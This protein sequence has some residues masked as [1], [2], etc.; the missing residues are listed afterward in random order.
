VCTP[1]CAVRV[2][3]K[4]PVHSETSFKQ[5]DELEAEF[6]A[7]INSNGA[8][9]ARR[10]VSLCLARAEAAAEEERRRQLLS[11]AGASPQRSA[12]VK[13]LQECPARPAGGQSPSRPNNGVL[14]CPAYPIAWNRGFY[15]AQLEPTA[16]SSTH[17][18]RAASSTGGCLREDAEDSDE[19]YERIL[20]S[21]FSI[22]GKVH[23]VLTAAREEKMQRQPRQSARLTCDLRKI[24]QISGDIGQGRAA[25]ER[26]KGANAGA[27]PS[28]RSTKPEQPQLPRTSGSRRN[29]EGSQEPGVPCIQLSLKLRNIDMDALN[30]Q[31]ST[32]GDLEA[33]VKQAVAEEMSRDIQPS[34]VD[35]RLVR[36]EGSAAMRVAVTPPAC[37]LPEVVQAVLGTSLSFQANVLEKVRN[38]PGIAAVCIGDVGVGEVSVSELGTVQ[39]QEILSRGGNLAVLAQAATGVNS[40]NEV[41]PAVAPPPPT[42]TMQQNSPQPARRDASSL[43]PASETSR[44]ANAERKAMNEDLG[45]ELAKITAELRRSRIIGDSDETAP[46]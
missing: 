31:P 9:S 44:M 45:K 28:S 17:V 18:Q 38:T 12:A 1:R 25:A 29:G 46:E 30:A 10:C 11:F 13:S 35:V 19:D 26:E 6:Q 33:S 40:P 4:S 21:A 16:R 34:H 27:N 15:D 23:D 43:S 42:G 8:N 36:S 20:R 41:Y 14:V 2:E 32:L 5:V 24:L 37:V 39:R 22:R 3:Q 7:I